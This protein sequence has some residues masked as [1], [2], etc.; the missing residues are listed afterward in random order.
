[1]VEYEY[2]VL[3]FTREVSRADIRRTLADHAEYGHWELPHRI[4]LGGVQRT[5]L[6]RRI[7]RATRT[8]WAGLSRRERDPGRRHGPAVNTDR[9]GRQYD[10]TSRCSTLAPNSRASTGTVDHVDHGRNQV[11]VVA[12]AG[13]GGDADGSGPCCPVPPKWPAT[14]APGSS[15]PGRAHRL[16][17]PPNGASRAMSRCTTSTSTCSPA[18]SRIV[19]MS[20]SSW[21]GRNRQS[22]AAVAD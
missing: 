19:A 17:A 2:R 1:M 20:E 16:G 13:R 8:A 11:A 3:K 21:P 10:R 18:S 14:P 9:P 4:C 22:T 7:I 15:S 12:G 6:R 5:W